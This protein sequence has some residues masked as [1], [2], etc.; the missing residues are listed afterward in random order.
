MTLPGASF[1]IPLIV[2]NPIKTY[3]YITIGILLAVCPESVR[4]AA[5]G[6]EVF[7][8]EE[9]RV[10]STFDRA[11]DLLRRG[12]GAGAADLL[13]V[14]YFHALTYRPHEPEWEGRDRFLLSIGHYAIALYAAL[15]EAGAV[16]RLGNELHVAP[17]AA[18]AFIVELG[19]R[20]AL[21]GVRTSE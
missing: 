19:R 12:N 9:P 14:A 11:E 5:G 21:E 4:G 16:I 7:L 20:Q 17:D 15:I 8:L 1:I 18:D 13:A 10:R 2:I 3:I 6:G